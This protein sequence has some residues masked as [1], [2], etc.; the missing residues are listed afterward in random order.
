MNGLKVKSV[1]VTQTQPFGSH[2]IPSVRS[3]EIPS[4]FLN[5]YALF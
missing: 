4:R 3:V 1:S 5:G 2:T